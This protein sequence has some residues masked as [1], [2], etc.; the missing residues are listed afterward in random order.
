MD[1]IGA[2]G[3]GMPPMQMQG[4]PPSAQEIAGK[5]IEEKDSDGSGGLS[6]DEVKLDTE[7]FAKL[8]ANS[9]GQLQAEELQTG[10]EEEMEAMEQLGP[11]KMGGQHRSPEDMAREIMSQ[12]DLDYTGTL[13]AEEIGDTTVFDELDT[14]E[15]GVVDMQELAAAMKPPEPPENGTVAKAGQG[16]TMIGS[17]GAMTGSEEASSMANIG[18]FISAADGTDEEESAKTAASVLEEKDIS[19]EELL[20]EEQGD[21]VDQMSQLAKNYEAVDIVA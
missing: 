11:P 4:K 5:I 1:S 10:I 13:S 14:N 19:L 18:N 20:Q 2:I 7:A 16:Q 12:S 3:G 9:D 8:D 6:L 15:D 21:E 17:M